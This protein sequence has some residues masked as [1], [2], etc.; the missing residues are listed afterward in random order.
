MGNMQEQMGNF[1]SRE[2]EAVRK[3]LVKMLEIRDS[4]R[5]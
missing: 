2:M 1:S 5:D 4:N 3:S